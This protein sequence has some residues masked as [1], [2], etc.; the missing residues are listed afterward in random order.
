MDAA[1]GVTAT[2]DNPPRLGNISTRAQ[3][4]TGNDVMIGGFIIGGPRSRAWRSSHGPV[5]HAVRHHQRARQSDA[6]P[7]EANPTRRP[8]RPTTTGRARA[9]RRSCRRPVRAIRTARVG[10]PRRP[11]PGAYT[12]IVSGVGGGTGVGVIA[13]YEVDHPEIPL[14]NISTRGR[15]SRATT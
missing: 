5:A 3:V 13:V 2:F 15:C 1:K 7:G 10:D 8:S 12:A 11:A 14:I 4:L 6:H 9:T